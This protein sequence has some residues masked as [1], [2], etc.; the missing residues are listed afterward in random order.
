MLLIAPSAQNDAEAHKTAKKVRTKDDYLFVPLKEAEKALLAGE[1]VGIRRF[2]DFHL[3]GM[4]LTLL[5]LA[6][7]H[8]KADSE[9]VCIHVD[10]G[11]D[12]TVL[13]AAYYLALARYPFTVSVADPQKVGGSSKWAELHPLLV[14][15]LTLTV[16][17]A[18]EMVML[19]TRETA[20]ALFVAFPAYRGNVMVP[21]APEQSASA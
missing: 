6:E 9:D 10:L 12:L 5:K 1:Y 2:Y 20:A 21:S 8:H 4:R 18:A 16:L 17:N 13:Y 3:P 15:K 14:R 11:D 19:P 7:K